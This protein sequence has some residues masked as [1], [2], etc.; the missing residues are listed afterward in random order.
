M[1][2]RK[3]ERER[4]DVEIEGNRRLLQSLKELTEKAKEA[5]RHEENK[6]EQSI[7]RGEAQLHA[8]ATPYYNDVPPSNFRNNSVYKDTN[9][10]D[11]NVSPSFGRENIPA[12][13]SRGQPKVEQIPKGV[14]PLRI[15]NRAVPVIT[16]NIVTPGVQVGLDT[17]GTPRLQEDIRSEA[18]Q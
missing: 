15:D 1:T 5:Y 6:L 10:F 14:V 3:A 9:S 18:S 13:L 12:S 11:N 7:L 17:R 16:R 2:E 4:L 8:G